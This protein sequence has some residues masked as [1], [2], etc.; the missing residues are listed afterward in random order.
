MSG[1][2]DSSVAAFLLREQGLYDV[3]GAFIKGYNV[4][5][6][7]DRESEDARRVAEHLGIPFYVI[8]LEEEYKQ[9][10]V[11]YLVN[12]YRNGITPNPDVMCNKE[13]KFG[14]F[15]EKALA[16]GAN[17]VA[18][19]HYVRIS[20]FKFQISNEDTKT[21]CALQQGIDDNKDQSYFL[22]TLRQGQL[23]HCLFPIGAYTK[24]EIRAIATKAGLSTAQK[25]DSQGICFLG[26][27]SLR[28]FLEQYLPKKR[29]DIITVDGKKVGEHDGAWFYTIGQRH[30][31]GI[32]GGPAYF[33]VKKD[34]RNNIV[35]VAHTEGLLG[36]A[37][38]HIDL[39]DVNFM[40][41][42]AA[43]CPE[44]I[45]VMAR[46]RYRQALFSAV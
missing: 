32:G 29:G 30:G 25:K 22:W 4:D 31:L 1:G 23:K 45:P 28:E 19:G 9:F 13:I 34:V 33:V 8:D 16:L 7:Q 14:V 24:P 12:G 18:T 2:V 6:C 36:Q 37:I 27:I 38:D 46:I 3:V 43:Q 41:I 15:L 17:F 11:E 20:N 10:V 44:S 40:G 42:Y 5:G 26:N 39:V 21:V 35:T